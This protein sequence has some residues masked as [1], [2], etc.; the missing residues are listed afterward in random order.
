M[1]QD[2]FGYVIILNKVYV[3]EGLKLFEH[4]INCLKAVPKLVRYL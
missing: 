1:F 4:S 2:Q 3:V